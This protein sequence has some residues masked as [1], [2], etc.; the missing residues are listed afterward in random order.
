MALNI[1]NSLRQ[2]QSGRI[3][4]SQKLCLLAAG[5]SCL[6]FAASAHAFETKARNAILMDYE[7]APIC[8]PKTIR[9]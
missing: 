9:K 7:T 6:S 3:S 2:N 4:L 1:T 5:I 8:S